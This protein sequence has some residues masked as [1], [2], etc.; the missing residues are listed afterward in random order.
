MLRHPDDPAQDL[1]IAVHH[2]LAFGRLR[3]TSPDIDL[4]QLG[5]QLPGYTGP[6]LRPLGFHFAAEVHHGARLPAEYAETHVALIPVHAQSAPAGNPGVRTYDPHPG[7]VLLTGMQGPFLD[8][9]GAG[10]LV[11]GIGHRLGTAVAG[12]EAA[13]LALLALAGLLYWL[14]A[15]LRSVGQLLGPRTDIGFGALFL[16]CAALGPALQLIPLLRVADAAVALAVLLGTARL[17]ALL[18]RLARRDHPDHGA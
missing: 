9:D 6:F 1:T 17:L 8:E 7:E 15:G 12:L 2:R 5:K 16:V 13:A 3:F 4:E 11:R 10:I 18:P 14:R